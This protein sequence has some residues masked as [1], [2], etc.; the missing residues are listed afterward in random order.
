MVLVY[1]APPLDENKAD[2]MTQPQDLAGRCSA[3][4]LRRPRRSS[5]RAPIVIPAR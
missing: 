5:A 2:P 4:A 3:A 1:H